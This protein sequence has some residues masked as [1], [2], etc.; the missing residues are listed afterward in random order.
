M[1]KYLDILES[2]RRTDREQI[3]D[4]GRPEEVSRGSIDGL[5]VMSNTFIPLKDFAR[6]EVD[7]RSLEG[8]V[9][10]D[11]CRIEIFS[12]KAGTSQTLLPEYFMERRH[13]TDFV[14]LLSKYIESTGLDWDVGTEVFQSDKRY[15][16]ASEKFLKLMKKKSELIYLTDPDTGRGESLWIWSGRRFVIR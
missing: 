13:I 16:H 3:I 6:Y 10:S 11:I 2:L 5:I 7:L 14:R 9:T 4:E 15:F 8:T 1:G 12:R